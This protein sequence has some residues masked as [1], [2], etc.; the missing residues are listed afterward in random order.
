M[1]GS[2]LV[3]VTHVWSDDQER[4]FDKFLALRHSGAPEVWLL[5]DAR[6]SREHDLAGKY[7]RFYEFDTDSLFRRLPYQ[8]LEGNGLLHN[9]HFPLMDF[10]LTHSGY[11][12]YWH[13]E[14]DVRYTGN[15]G[16]F[17][18]QFDARDDDFITCHI[19]RFSEEPDWYWWNFFSHPQKT[20]PRDAFI[21]SYNVI[22]RISSRALAFLHGQFEDGWRGHSEVSFPT[23]L[24]H[25]GFSIRDFGGDGDFVFPGMANRHYTSQGGSRGILNPF[26]SLHWRP[27]STHPGLRRDTLYHPV[28]PRDM[29]EAW[30]ERW[31]YY[32]KWLRQYLNGRTRSG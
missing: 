14:F 31:D 28:K 25:G 18:R 20:I 26:C 7:S 32:K 19:R 12:Y 22:F 23:L 4:E 1:T 2:A 5:A 21:R 10:Y 3:W 6:I 8:R 15:W 30:G 13:V 16:S 29:T 24:S 9:T 17:L 11:D 27:A